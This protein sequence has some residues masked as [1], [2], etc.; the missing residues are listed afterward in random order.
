MSSQAWQCLHLH[1]SSDSV[2]AFFWMVPQTLTSYLV[3]GLHLPL[4]PAPLGECQCVQ[5]LALADVG[6]VGSVLGL[7]GHRQ[8]QVCGQMWV[9]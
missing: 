6:L 4:G 7:V 5:H 8:Q 9:V 2:D 1:Y 3:N